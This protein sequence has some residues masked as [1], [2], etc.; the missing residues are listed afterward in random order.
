ME[1]LLQYLSLVCSIL[2][3]V[4][5]AAFFF[6]G[7]W[8]DWKEVK[9]KVLSSSSPDFASD[10]EDFRKELDGKFST[11]ATW[12]ATEKESGEAGGAV[13]WTSL[14][15][16]SGYYVTGIDVNG[17]DAKYCNTC[18]YKIKANCRPLNQ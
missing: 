3:F 12:S 5:T 10:I 7:E 4:A 2:V 13:G 9:G 8:Q 15:C 1:K 14:E 18:I 11:L 17:Y 6:G 16:P